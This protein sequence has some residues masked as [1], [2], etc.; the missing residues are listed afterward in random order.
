MLSLFQAL[1][2]TTKLA[3][4][5]W[6]ESISMETLHTGMIPILSSIMQVLPTE[7]LPILTSMMQWVLGHFNLEFVKD[8]KGL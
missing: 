3:D 8:Q 5:V 4:I 1:M 7:M 6:V 2:H